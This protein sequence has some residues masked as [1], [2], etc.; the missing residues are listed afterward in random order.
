MILLQNLTTNLDT[1]N[2]ELLNNFNNDFKETTYHI[3]ELNSNNLDLRIFIMNVK[4]DS[5]K[6]M[7]CMNFKC[8]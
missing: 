8:Y 1:N 3:E 2:I 4:K 7:H 6:V 5:V